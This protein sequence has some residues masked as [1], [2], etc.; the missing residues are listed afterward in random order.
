MQ[1]GVHIDG[2][3]ATSGGLAKMTALPTT[4][5]VGDFID[6]VVREPERATE[7]LAAHP[8][9]LNARWLHGE[10]VLHFLAVEGFA[11]GVR[12]LAEHGADVNAV[13]DFGHPP[14]LDVARRGIAQIAAT[15]L[16]HGANPNAR[17]AT[18]GPALHCALERGQED[19]VALLLAAGADGRLRTYLDETV[20]DVLP[21]V[22]EERARLLALL[23]RYGITDDSE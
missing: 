3:E 12:F 1:S 15:L 9:L 7:L 23:A 16:R 19:V 22:G 20:F 10:T 5:L 17:S 6:A 4:E 14:L 8:Q 11:D 21:P 13:N 18:D 2:N